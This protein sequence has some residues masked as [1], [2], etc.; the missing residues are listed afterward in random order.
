MEWAEARLKTHVVLF[1]LWPSVM[2]AFRLKTANYMWK[3]E[4]LLF[5]HLLIFSVL[6]VIL[7]FLIWFILTLLIVFLLLVMFMTMN[8]SIYIT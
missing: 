2:L 5:L 1:V 6:T 3:K 7:G 4:P 8:I